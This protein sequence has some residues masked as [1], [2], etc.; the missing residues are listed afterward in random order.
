MAFTPANTKNQ[1]I[2]A[3]V[4][5]VAK[6]TETA[7]YND[8]LANVAP[9]SQ[10]AVGHDVRKVPDLRAFSDPAALVD[11]RGFMGKIFFFHLNCL[12]S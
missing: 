9:F 10:R 11:D 12:Q 1:F 6:G 8:I 7:A 5:A 2:Q 4:E 3:G